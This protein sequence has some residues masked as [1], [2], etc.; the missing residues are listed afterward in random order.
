MQI[1]LDLF[2]AVS[3]ST[4]PHSILG[5]WLAANTS[6]SDGATAEALPS[7]KAARQLRADVRIA[8][9]ID[10]RGLWVYVTWSFEMSGVVPVRY[11]LN[12]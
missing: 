12:A 10:R 8:L 9:A 1:W 11:H 6:H 3:G 2:F 7:M 4:L 5:F